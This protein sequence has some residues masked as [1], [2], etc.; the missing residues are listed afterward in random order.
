MLTVNVKYRGHIIEAV[1]DNY[2]EPYVLL[3]AWA[4]KFPNQLDIIDI[5]NDNQIEDIENLVALKF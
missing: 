1:L 4:G 2:E 5:L 3:E